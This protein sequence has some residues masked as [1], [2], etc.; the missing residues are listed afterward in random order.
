M[1]TKAAPNASPVKN[2]ET[3]V[4][5]PLTGTQ[6]VM[7]D[8]NA[9]SFWGPSTLLDAANADQGGTGYQLLNTALLT[10]ATRNIYTFLAGTSS[11]VDLTAASNALKETNASLTKTLLGN[12]VMTDATRATL[13]NFARGGNPGDANCSDADSA[14]ACTAWRAWPHAARRAFEASGGHLRRDDGDTHANP[15]FPGQ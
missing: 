15:V 13:I 10:P 14:T 7:V 2:I 8:P 6:E 5:D 1:L 12:A 11:T 4:V 9:S 3:I